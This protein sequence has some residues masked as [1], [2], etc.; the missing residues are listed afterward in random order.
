MTP[1]TPRYLGGARRG[2]CGLVTLEVLREK[3]QLAHKSVTEHQNSALE[4]PQPSPA[5]PCTLY[6]YLG[7]VLCVSVSAPASCPGPVQESWKTLERG[8]NALNKCIRPRNMYSLSELSHVP[9]SDVLVQRVL[10]SFESFPGFLN[11]RFEQERLLPSLPPG[12]NACS[13]TMRGAR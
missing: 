2:A 13:R 12:T 9:L 7:Y 1:R 3:T 8:Q 4:P 10:T 11:K 5:L 6:T